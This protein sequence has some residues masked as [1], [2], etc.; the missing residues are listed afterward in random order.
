M[1]TINQLVRKGRKT[2][3]A[4]STAPALQHGW[5]SKNKT[6]TDNKAP[7][8]RGICTLR[9]ITDADANDAEA[10]GQ[11]DLPVSFHPGNR[12]YTYRPI[13]EH[14]PVAIKAD[15]YFQETK[16]DAMDEL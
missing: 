12:R 15:E 14:L 4:K 9:I 10:V 7:Q 1:P 6:V 5:N 3:K 11:K 13:K 2:T 16:H 8:K